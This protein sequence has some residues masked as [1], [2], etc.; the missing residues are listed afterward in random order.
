MR[1]S[2]QTTFSKYRIT[3]QNAKIANKYIVS[4]NPRLYLNKGLT[5]FII[6]VASIVSM[7][8]TATVTD[9]ITQRQSNRI[10]AMLAGIFMII[11]CEFLLTNIVYILEAF[12]QMTEMDVQEAC[13]TQLIKA[14][15]EKSLTEIEDPDVI[16]V[17]FYAYVT[18]NLFCIFCR[19]NNI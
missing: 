15:K 13:K 5:E 11:I 7:T 19:V 18:F 2:K 17:F 9:I 1:N 6:P 8:A 12:S 4:I 16:D 14:L 3:L 10:Y